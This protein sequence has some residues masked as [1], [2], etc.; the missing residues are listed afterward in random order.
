MVSLPPSADHICHSAH[1]QDDVY[2]RPLALAHRGASSIVTCQ[3]LVSHFGSRLTATDPSTCPPAA[4]EIE[5]GQPRTV[6]IAT[7]RPVKHCH[8]T[9]SF[10]LPPAWS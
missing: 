8:N 2:H 10:S 9:D 6:P 3:E 1:F 7:A 4:A 5:T